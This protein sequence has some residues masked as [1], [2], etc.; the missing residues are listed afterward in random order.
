[1]PKRFRTLDELTDFLGRR[2][3]PWEEAVHAVDDFPALRDAVDAVR[4]RMPGIG[5]F[6][7]ARRIACFREVAQQFDELVQRGLLTLDDAILALTVLRFESGAFR[8]AARMFLNRRENYL[9]ALEQD[10]MPMLTR[11]YM[12]VLGMCP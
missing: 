6:S 2:C 11:C 4:K 10:T 5:F 1:M 8:K 7:P 9:Q 3:I 12:R